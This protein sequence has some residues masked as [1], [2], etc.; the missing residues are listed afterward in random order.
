MPKLRLGNLV[1]DRDRQCV[2]V[3]NQATE[4]TS[5]ELG[6]LWHMARYAER[7]LTRERLWRA[8]WGREAKGPTR[9]LDTH[10]A[11]LRR[12][13]SQPWMI[14]AVPRRGY[15]LTDRPRASTTKHSSIKPTFYSDSASR[16]LRGGF[17]AWLKV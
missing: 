14:R 8:V 13:L 17:N 16:A 9:T 11:R 3:G 6:L 12:K 1:I 15:V 4:L 7:V 5:T 10:I 2:F